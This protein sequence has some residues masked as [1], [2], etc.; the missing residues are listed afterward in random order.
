MLDLSFKVHVDGQIKKVEQQLQSAAHVLIWPP[1][2]HQ[3]A[4]LSSDWLA[5]SLTGL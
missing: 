4:E 2:C 3:R 1:T 5:G